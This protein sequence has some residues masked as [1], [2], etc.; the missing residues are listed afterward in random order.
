MKAKVW[1]ISLIILVLCVGLVVA[2][3]TSPISITE[4][5]SGRSDLSA[6]GV[7]VDAYAGNVTGL[8]IKAASITQAWAG[9]YGNI[10]GNILL[11]DALNNTMYNW[12]MTTIAGEVYAS[13][14]SVTDWSGVYC[15]N[16]TTTKNISQIE[17]WLNIGASDADGVDETFNATF[18]G[19]FGVGTV[20]ID[21]TDDCQQA[22][23]FKDQAW[24]STDFVEVILSAEQNY[25][26]TAILENNVDGFKS[27]VDSHDFQI[28]VGE[29]GHNGD[30]SV[31]PYYFYVELG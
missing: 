1:P 23:T 16:E 9:F 29:D 11:D 28:L 12:S 6:A 3:P 26:W 24:Q 25:I 19:S 17:T 22:T 21:A 15:V 10:T 20:T 27:G 7:Q 31:T 5:A 13:N 2:D 18:A 4:G 30:A 14:G 8:D